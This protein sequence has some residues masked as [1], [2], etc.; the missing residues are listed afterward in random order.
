MTGPDR[1]PEGEME[2][3][4]G[5]EDRWGSRPFFGKATCIVDYILLPNS[6]RKRM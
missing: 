2:K 4:K 3:G 5:E 1:T 6:R